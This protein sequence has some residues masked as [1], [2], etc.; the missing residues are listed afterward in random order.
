MIVA[1]DAMGGDHGPP[2]NVDASILTVQNFK[3]IDVLLVGKEEAL[4][5]ELKDRG[6]SGDR[7]SILNATETVDMDE[8][9]SMALRRKKDSSLRRSVEMVRDGRADAAVSAGNSGAMMAYGL[10]LLRAAEGVDRPALAAA[11]PSEKNPFLFLDMGA[12]IDCSPDNLFQFAC[13]GSA[14]AS[15]VMNVERPRVALLSIGEEANKGNELTKEAYKLLQGSRM[16]FIGNIES[17]AIFRGEADVVVCDGFPGNVF[18]KTTEGLA[19][20]LLKMIKQEIMA[21]TFAKIGYLFMRSAMKKVA[22]RMDYD[23]YGGATLLGLNGACIITH[24]RASAKA[25]MSGIREASDYA[26][27]KVY[28]KISQEIKSYYE[29]KP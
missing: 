29:P 18:L 24:G 4:A 16:N 21:S 7:I 23:E 3:H 26:E 10:F 15:H 27:K 9:P 20:T 12:N 2:V 1:L 6:Y 11:M 17:K 5:R 14:Y 25:I 13:M 19:D 22:R 8:S 28:E